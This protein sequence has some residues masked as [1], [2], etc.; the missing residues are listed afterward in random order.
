MWFSKLIKN[1]VDGLFNFDSGSTYKYRVVQ[2]NCGKM[3]PKEVLEKVAP[4]VT[5]ENLYLVK[6]ESL[7]KPCHPTLQ[8]NAETGHRNW[9]VTVLY[10]RLNG[11][12][13]DENERTE[14]FWLI[15]DDQT[16]EIGE[17]IYPR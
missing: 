1:L 8:E 14:C 16:E 17:K 15:V 4:I 13:L 5:E 2:E 3:T 10:E 11:K 9:L 6:K 7:I 12:L